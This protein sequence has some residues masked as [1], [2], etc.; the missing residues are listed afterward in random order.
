MADEKS[1]NHVPTPAYRLRL[2]VAG[3]EPNS[4]NARTVLARLC[5]RYLKGQYEIKVV[6]VLKDYQAAIADRV[7][8]VPTLFVESP[9]GQS[10]IV[11][12]LSDEE[13]VVAAFGLSNGEVRR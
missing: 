7:M 9:T 8:A 6:D 5:E 12:S 10:I 1:L 2:F 4:M 13:K 3:G 11:G